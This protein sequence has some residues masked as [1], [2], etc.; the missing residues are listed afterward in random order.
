MNRGHFK[1]KFLVALAAVY[2]VVHGAGILFFA[3]AG[4]KFS[5][6]F[7]VA[8]P[9]LAAVACLWQ[10]WVS[11]P[12]MRLAWS[13]LAS[14][15]GLWSAGMFVSAL[16][17][18]AQ[19]EIPTLASLSDFL[20]FAYCI[21]MLLV[22][23]SPM[24][25]QR[26]PMFVWLDAAQAVCAGC[27]LYVLLFSALP[28]DG[29]AA[30]PVSMPFVVTT[31]NVENLLLA[32]FATI[33]LLLHERSRNEGRMYRMLATYLWVYAALAALNNYLVPK[34]GDQTGLL[35][36]VGDPPFPADGG[37]D[38]GAQDKAGCRA[39]VCA[40]PSHGALYR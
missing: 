25:T 24:E 9:L 39:E 10:A 22:I 32:I 1:R 26:S 40:D 13:T 4:L 5:Y 33:R 35:D 3:P 11:G 34:L 16:Q 21:P 38:P 27:L 36:L 8:T 29:H 37:I 15:F 19:R 30:K 14:G 20:F 17:Y 6:P 31:E 28:F 23:I 12:R 18:W 7:L 2:M